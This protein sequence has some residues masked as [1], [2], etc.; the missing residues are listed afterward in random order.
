MALYAG[1]LWLAGAIGPARRRPDGSGYDIL[2]TGTSHSE[3]WLRAHLGPLARSRHCA[4]IRMVSVM[5]VPALPK[6]ETICP[7]ARLRRLVGDVGARLLTFAWVGVRSR[8]HIVGGFHLLVNGLVAALLARAI[9]ARA[10]Y[11]CVGGPAEVIDGGIRTEN[12]VFDA[13]GT[14]DKAVERRLLQAVDACDLVVTMGT[15]AVRYF[16]EQGVRAPIHVVAGGIDGARFRPEPGA[17]AVDLIL[18]ARLVPIKRI[19]RFLRALHAVRAEVPAA[20][21]TIVGD[22]PERARLERLAG[23]LG[24]EGAVRFAGEQHD[25]EPWLRR[26]RIFVLTSESEG[27]SLSMIEAMSCG[28]PA[29]VPAVGDLGDLVEDGV[30]GYLVPEHGPDAFAARLVGLLHDPARLARFSA[31]AIAAASRYDLVPATRLWDQLL[32]DLE[33]GHRDRVAHP[34]SPTAEGPAPARAL[35]RPG[36]H[37]AT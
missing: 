1:A 12:R 6:V 33:A 36:G 8:P 23:E 24:L 10:M 2:L 27:L 4:R 25:V 26:A 20:T 17:A 16:R 22:G 18:V 19:D 34:S 5:N 29:V 3:N 11:F 14:P 30:N 21:A 15:G 13:L 31:A 28:L 32:G 37:D 35:P 9:G 7:P